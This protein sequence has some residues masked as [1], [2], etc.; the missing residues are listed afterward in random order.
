M[1]LEDAGAAQRA[2]RPAAA[3][4]RPADASCSSRPRPAAGG[5]ST[6][7][8]STA[9]STS[10]RSCPRSSR[11]RPAAR[12]SRS[13]SA[14]R[15]TTSSTPAPRSRSSSTS[16]PPSTAS[17]AAAS[18]SPSRGR[19]R[20][21]RNIRTRAVKDGGDWVIN[22][23]KTFITGG[24]EADF[25]MVFAVTDP[26]KG[27]DGGVDLLP[28]R[29]RHG[30]EV[31]ADPDDGRVGARRRWSF[32]DVRVPERNILGELGQGFTLAMQWIGNGRYMIPPR[33]IGSAERLL[34]DGDRARQEPGVHGPPDRRLPGDPVADRRLARGDRV[35]Q[36]AD[37][38]RRLA[39][40]ERAAT[41]GTPPRSPS[42]PAR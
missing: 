34:G 27:A 32:E 42:C 10:A 12:S 9:A 28:G 4:A 5:A 2:R 14:A 7:P 24:N 15:P 26:D 6:R 36:V 35:G 18:R 8:R 33:A 11:W 29:P 17:A 40:A 38:A 23:E 20:T 31:R 39:A 30:L 3:R 19:A 1:P 25:V 37:A 21:P 13:G 16:S 41:P 22:G